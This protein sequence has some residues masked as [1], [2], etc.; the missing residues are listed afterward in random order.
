M[1]FHDVGRGTLNATFLHA[2]L[3]EM[4]EK[5]AYIFDGRKLLD[6]IHSCMEHGISMPKFTDL[7]QLRDSKYADL[8]ISM[9]QFMAST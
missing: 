6:H 4:E 1:T 9:D 7:V 5:N 8:T 3:L 2:S